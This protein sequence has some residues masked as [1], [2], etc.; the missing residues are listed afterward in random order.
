VAIGRASDP[1]VRLADFQWQQPHDDIWPRRSTHL[2]LF[3]R[4]HDRLTN[5][6]AMSRQ[7][8]GRPTSHP[9]VFAPWR[10]QEAANRR[11]LLTWRTRRRPCRKT[12]TNLLWSGC[13]A[14]V[15]HMRSFY[16]M[17]RLRRIGRA[18]IVWRKGHCCGSSCGH[19][20]CTR[21]KGYDTCGQQERIKAGHPCLLEGF[22]ARP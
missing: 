20:L 3:P 11:F 15:V 19:G 8:D 13:H 2:W 22:S 6:E 10:L 1:I 14:R 4:H 12:G 7:D 16:G 18:A 17:T 9:S 5:P 21:R